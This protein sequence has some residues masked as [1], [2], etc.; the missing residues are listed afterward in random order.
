MHKDCRCIC[1]AFEFA[2]VVGKNHKTFNMSP[3]VDNAITRGGIGGLGTPVYINALHIASDFFLKIIVCVIQIHYVTLSFWTWFCIHIHF[4]CELYDTWLS[5]LYFL[6]NIYSLFEHFYTHLS[7]IT[8]L[9]T[10]PFIFLNNPILES[11]FTWIQLLSTSSGVFILILARFEWAKW[12][13]K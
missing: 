4:C 9:G 8:I 5:N 10:Q 1:F 11:T 12:D 2:C 13:H 7:I 3:M 6:S